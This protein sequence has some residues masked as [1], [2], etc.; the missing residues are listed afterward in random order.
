MNT[1]PCAAVLIVAR[2]NNAR[3][4]DELFKYVAN[5]S[6]PLGYKKLTHLI[7]RRVEKRQG[8]PQHLPVALYPECRPGEEPVHF[9]PVCIGVRISAALMIFGRGQTSLR[10]FAKRAI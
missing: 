7:W 4:R 2:K 8:T 1:Q 9:N 10:Y 5:R 3:R 6:E